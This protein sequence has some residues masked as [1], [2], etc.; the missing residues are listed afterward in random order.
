MEQMMKPKA[1]WITVGIASCMAL[2]A[3]PV[4]TAQAQEAAPHA[5][6]VAI[7]S[8]RDMETF[9]KEYGPKVPATL[10]PFGGRYLVRGGKLMSLEGE[11]PSRFVIIEFDSMQ[12]ALNW[13]RSPRYQKL[14]PLR[15]EA[16]KSTLFIADGASK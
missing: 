8:V 1:R 11:A 7:E 12:N 2:V 15:Q 14:I 16:S 5:F 3:S 9:T 10:Q 13:Y 4:A 6:V